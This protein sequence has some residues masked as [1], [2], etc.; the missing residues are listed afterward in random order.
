[1][2]AF[3]PFVLLCG[4]SP[5]LTLRIVSRTTSFSGPISLSVSGLP[6]GAS[7]P[8]STSNSR[9]L[10]VFLL[11]FH[12]SRQFS[13]DGHDKRAHHSGRGKG[14]A[15]AVFIET[16]EILTTPRHNALRQPQVWEQLPTA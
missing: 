6:A 11:L 14:S 8:N 9:S 1:M 13:A 15:T 7:A 4:A 5:L 10:S 12:L 16:P 2:G 3:H